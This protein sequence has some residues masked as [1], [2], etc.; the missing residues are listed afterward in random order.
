[1]IAGEKAIVVEADEESILECRVLVCLQLLVESGKEGVKAAT[2]DEVL[3]LPQSPVALA[4]PL[5]FL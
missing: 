1:M 2:F 3:C 5:T 4:V